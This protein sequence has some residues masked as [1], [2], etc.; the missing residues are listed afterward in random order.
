[1][2]VAKWLAGQQLA[3][4]SSQGH[5]WT[6]FPESFPVRWATW[7]SFIQS[8]MGTLPSSPAGSFNREDFVNQENSRAQRWKEPGSQV[9]VEICSPTRNT[10]AGLYM[11]R[12]I[13][14]G[15]LPAGFQCPYIK[16][17]YL[18]KNKI[19]INIS[20]PHLGKQSLLLNSF[21]SLRQRGKQG[22]WGLVKSI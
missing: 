8:N 11:R 10:H 6:Y 21:F 12:E 14:S 2:G 3:T 18:I 1:M 16:D 19:S 15:K 13:T 22:A 20:F 17:F 4:L 5:S 9:T 7:L